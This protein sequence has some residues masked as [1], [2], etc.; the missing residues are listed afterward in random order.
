MGSTILH[1]DKTLT[2]PTTSIIP[3]AYDIGTLGTHHLYFLLSL[4]KNNVEIM[5]DSKHICDICSLA[6]Q[7][8]LPFHYSEI[9][10][11][12]PFD[13]IHCDIWGPHR[14]QIHYGARY[15]LTIMDDFTRF[16]WV[17]FMN[18]KSNTQIILKSFFSWVETQFQ[19]D[20]KTLRADNGSEFLSMRS[21]L[22]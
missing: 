6:K 1:Q 10:T 2:S 4:A 20:I 9:K 15:F 17:H 7:T 14:N 8:C 11:S 13:L 5:F 22:D 19:C 12:T 16:T 18:F 3:L 21:Y